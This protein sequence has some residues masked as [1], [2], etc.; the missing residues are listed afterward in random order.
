MIIKQDTELM[1]T[2]SIVQPNPE[3]LQWDNPIA[4]GGGIVVIA[5]AGYISY[6]IFKPTEHNPTEEPKNPVPDSTE[7]PASKPTEPKKSNPEPV[8]NPTE[9][10]K[11]IEEPKSVETKLKFSGFQTIDLKDLNEETKTNIKIL[12][13]NYNSIGPFSLQNLL[14]KIES[15]PLKKYINLDTTNV[16]KLKE[17]LTNFWNK[18]KLE[19]KNTIKISAWGSIQIHINDINNLLTEKTTLQT[20]IVDLLQLAEE[21]MTDENQEIKLTRHDDKIEFMVKYTPSNK[22]KK[23]H[24]KIKFNGFENIIFCDSDNIIERKIKVHIK[25]GVFAECSLEQLL[26]K[27]PSGDYIYLDNTKPLK[28]NENTTDL[29]NKLFEIHTKNSTPSS[30]ISL[31]DI[32]AKLNEAQHAYIADLL[33]FIGELITNEK[34]KIELTNIGN[35]YEFIIKDLPS[36]KLKENLNISS[37]KVD[38]FTSISN[39]N[40]MNN[41]CKSMIIYVS[42]NSY[43]L[44]NDL[45]DTEFQSIIDK[46][47]YLYLNVPENLLADNKKQLMRNIEDLLTKIKNIK[48]EYKT[49]TM[50]TINEFSTENKAYIIDAFRIAEAIYNHNFNIEI[51]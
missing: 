35:E 47:N 37:F 20:Y 44:K 13:N 25:E 27:I 45:K 5:A 42:P 33:Q 46:N 2:D 15:K 21:L 7:E 28:L 49:I 18:L 12:I 50:K 24:G 4:I 30:T 6:R 32:N 26:S 3:F 8:P 9:P 22:L 51:I 23:G 1:S 48:P 43:I 39:F 19:T 29:W 16:D 11:P 38:N 40:L 10:K 17:N 14:D 34:Q 31:N 36:N 41:I